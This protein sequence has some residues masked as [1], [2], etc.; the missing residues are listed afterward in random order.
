MRWVLPILALLLSACG[1]T[2]LDRGA[3]GY[4]H[5]EH[6]PKLSDT[7][8]GPGYRAPQ[9]DPGE[10]MTALTGGFTPHGGVSRLEGAWGGH[11]VLGAE[12]TLNLGE[13]DYNHFDDDFFVLPMRGVG[14]SV[15]LGVHLAGDGIYGLPAYTELHLFED[16]AGVAAGWAFDPVATATG[17]QATV[18][19]GPMFLRGTVYLDGSFL[20]SFGSQMKLPLMTWVAA[21]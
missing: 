18:W 12:L 10:Q 8:R 19:W 2:H 9:R 4:T 11:A 7:N 14:G 15:G 1:H 13:N 3:P 21:R 20:L 17:P 5:L 16:F 6:P